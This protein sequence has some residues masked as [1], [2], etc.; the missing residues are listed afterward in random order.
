[1]YAHIENCDFH[2]NEVSKAA[3]GTLDV[4]MLR[5]LLYTGHSL[6]RQNIDCD[7]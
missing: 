3:V 7:M 4:S 2:T 5:P 6:L 1:M